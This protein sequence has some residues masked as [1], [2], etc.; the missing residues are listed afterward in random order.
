MGYIQTYNF[1]I[2]V[3]HQK[4]YTGFRFRVKA[5][6]I[7]ERIYANNYSMALKF[8]YPSLLRC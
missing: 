5:V 8:F 7:V 1:L 6:I 4:Y 2:E 3:S